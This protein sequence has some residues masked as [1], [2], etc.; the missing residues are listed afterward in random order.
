MSKIIR[1]TGIRGLGNYDL[2]P[3]VAETFEPGSKALGSLPRGADLY[4]YGASRDQLTRMKGDWYFM[5]EDFLSSTEDAVQKLCLLDFTTSGAIDPVTGRVVRPIYTH[6]NLKHKGAAGRLPW[7][8]AE[9][10]LHFVANEDIPVWFGISR[11]MAFDVE[12]GVQYRGQ[13]D[14]RIHV[15]RTGGA[16]QVLVHRIFFPRLEQKEIGRLTSVYH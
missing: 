2:P 10:R 5:S 13:G 3:H 15:T 7:N 1:V 6:H 16:S 8:T 14:M 9:W 4:R 12:Q 11:A